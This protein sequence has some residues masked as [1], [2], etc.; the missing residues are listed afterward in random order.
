[1]TSSHSAK[2]TFPSDTQ[3]L[4]TRDFAA[5]KHLVY[6][7]VTTPELVKRWWNAK[8]GEVTTCEVDLRVGGKWRFV[9][10]TPDGFE[11]AFHGEYKEIV[12]NERVVT[13]EAYLGAP[14]PD[15][16][17]TTNTMTLTENDGVTTL[18]VLIDCP[19]EFVRNAIVES[20]MEEGLQ[21][22]YDLLEE[23]AISFR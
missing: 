20:G 14:D 23:V 4:I 21:D 7:A 19:N 1:M 5:P 22:A 18:T 15:V 9:M 8:R 3:I 11:V 16:N 2:L 17:A 13:T 12:P 10:E 6:R